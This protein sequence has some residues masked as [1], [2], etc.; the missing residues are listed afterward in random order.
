MRRGGTGTTCG[1][2]AAPRSPAAARPRA[3]LVSM[4][5]A[6]L[7]ATIAGM[8]PAAIAL[9]GEP[10]AGV[11]FQSA[12]TRRIQADD[13]ANPGL[14]WVEQGAALW[15]RPGTAGADATSCASCHAAPE[16]SMRGVA[17]RYP[18]VDPASG[19]LL[20]LEARI[21]ACRTEQM[22]A[23]ALPYESAELLALTALVS[24]QSRGLPRAVSIE[25]PA[26]AHYEAGR[27]FFVTRQGQ[28]NLACANCH[29][30]NVGRRLRGDVISQGQTH[31]WPGYRL[32]WQTFGSLHRRLRACSLG[33]RAEILPYGAPAYVDLELF[34]AHRG[35]GLAMESPGVRR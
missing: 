33:V 19:R 29:E 31:G 16:H 6:A 35:N 3:A 12:E 1:M 17:A 30:A 25:G 21:N 14:L 22:H 20:N 7:G 15:E 32:E 10:A 28:L 27:A 18:A 8:A 23:P 5:A 2:T 34:L 13:A 24:Y 26:R 9:A 11:S 4:L